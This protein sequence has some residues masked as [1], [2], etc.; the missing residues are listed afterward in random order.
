MDHGSPMNHR[1]RQY[2]TWSEF[3]IEI[4]SGTSSKNEILKYM[5]I[6]GQSGFYEY[7]WN[8]DQ[9]PDVRTY[10]I[11]VPFEKFWIC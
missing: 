3:F 9:I 8:L 2:G 10:T 1:S 6:S 11:S 4:R 5:T 7:F